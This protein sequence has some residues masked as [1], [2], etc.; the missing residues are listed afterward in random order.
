MTP[1][2]KGVLEDM[3]A[4]GLAI[5]RENF[6]LYNWAGIPV[7]W[8]DEHEAELPEDLQDWSLFKNRGGSRVYVGPPIET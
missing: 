4:A 8:D 7:E 3:R 5:T 2:L 1:G 6:I